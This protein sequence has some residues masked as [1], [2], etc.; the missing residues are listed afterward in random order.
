MAMCDAVK[1]ALELHLSA[2]LELPLEE[3]LRRR[4]KKYRRIGVLGGE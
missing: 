1:K 3:L 2:L 4:T